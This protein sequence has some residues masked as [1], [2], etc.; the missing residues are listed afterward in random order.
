MKDDKLAKLLKSVYATDEY[1]S[2]VLT[3]QIKDFFLD[4]NDILRF[5]GLVYILAKLKRSFVKEQHSLPAYRHQGI[6]RTF[7]KIARDYYFLG[8]RKYIEVVIGEYDLY[9]KSKS[10]RHAPYRLL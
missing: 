9:A 4:N 10:N 1:A 2:R 5:K 3:S 8:M 7:D 6:S